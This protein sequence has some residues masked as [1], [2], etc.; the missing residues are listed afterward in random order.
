MLQ[1]ITENAQWHLLLSPPP[2]FS[3]SHTF[4]FCL[5]PPYWLATEEPTLLS[6][7]QGFNAS[8]QRVFLFLSGKILHTLGIIDDSSIVYTPFGLFFFRDW[9]QRTRGSSLSLFSWLIQRSHI[10]WS[11]ISGISISVLPF[12]IDWFHLSYF[13]NGN[14]NSYSARLLGE[15]L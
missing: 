12:S 9:V 1:L 13:L 11:G 3:W 8:P 6:A 4:I 14:S 5:C 2:M 15:I 7:G 10:V